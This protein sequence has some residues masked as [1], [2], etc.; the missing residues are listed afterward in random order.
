MGRK[1]R[2]LLALAGLAVVFAI[3]AFVLWPR[4]ERITRE[5]FER[6][7]EGMTLAD[8]TA[9]L[10]PAHEPRAGYPGIWRLGVGSRDWPA[11]RCPRCMDSKPE[12][13]APERDRAVNS[14]G[15][16]NR[17]KREFEAGISLAVRELA[18]SLAR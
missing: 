8:V 16:V 10:G 6:I 11:P 17:R 9:L 14:R 12:I 3:G 18:G 15:T 2:W 1:L 13:P 5:N 7:H 4:P